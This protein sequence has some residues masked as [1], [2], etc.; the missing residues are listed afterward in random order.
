[1]LCWGA[2]LSGVPGGGPPG[3][4][5]F[6]AA[7]PHRRG[8]VLRH[9]RGTMDL[10]IAQFTTDLAPRT[11]SG[12][13]WRDC[14]FY[15]CVSRGGMS[16]RSP[17]QLPPRSCRYPSPRAP[18]PAQDQSIRLFVHSATVTATPRRCSSSTAGSPCVVV[19]VSSHRRFKLSV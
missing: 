15:C 7:P 2:L 5:R 14:W 12:R 4:R 9:G 19:V 17:A 13:H 18:T 10:L 11:H 6:L 8:I 16:L 3:H 1:M